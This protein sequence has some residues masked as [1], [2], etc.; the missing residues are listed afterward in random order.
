MAGK[1][2][3]KDE[4]GVQSKTARASM[5]GG[6][7]KGAEYIASGDVSRIVPLGGGTYAYV[8]DPRNGRTLK[9]SVKSDQFVEVLG[10]LAEAGHGDRMKRDLAELAARYPSG[11]WADAQTRLEATL[12]PVGGGEEAEA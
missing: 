11:G 9:M 4:S 10:A 1:V 6:A 2:K 5:R 3:K 12:A 8:L 7:A